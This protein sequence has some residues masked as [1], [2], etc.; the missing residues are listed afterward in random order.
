M[1]DNSPSPVKVVLGGLAAVVALIVVLG[2]IGFAA[3]WFGK[4]AEVAGP[5]NVERQY[6]QVIETFNS[7]QAAANNACAAGKSEKQDGDPVLIEKPD[8]AYG[9][10][11]RSQVV[12]Y[13]RR[14]ANIFEAKAVG[15]DG[16]PR[17][18]PTPSAN[19]DWC[20]Y[21]D[22]VAALKN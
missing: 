18:L 7:V 21:A 3:G 10:I 17:S 5:Q 6:H 4:A 2:V 12:D 15:P 9:A 20:A 22:K 14:Q 11:V 8:V 19:E 13:N 1:T 16:Y